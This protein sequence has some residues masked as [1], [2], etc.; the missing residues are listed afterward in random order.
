MN[1]GDE[2]AII[3]EGEFDDSDMIVGNEVMKKTA[4]DR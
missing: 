1:L 3:L 4:L 2:Q